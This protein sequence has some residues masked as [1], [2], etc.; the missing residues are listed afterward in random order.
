MLMLSAC[1]STPHSDR[2]RS[3]S[4][5]PSVASHTT[6]PSPAVLSFPQSDYFQHAQVEPLAFLNRLT[7]GSNRSSAAQLAMLG[8][9][10]F[11][12]QQLNAKQSDVPSTIQAQIERMTISQKPFLTMMQELDQQR[13][14]AAKMKGTDDTLRKAYQ[15]ELSRLAREAASR[16]VLRAVYS[17][18][19]LLEQMDWFWM[20]H[21]N[22]SSRKENLRAMLGDFEETAIRPNAL[23]HFRDLLRATILHPA[24]LRYLDNE[25]NAVGKI[26]ENYARELLE[27]HTMGVGSGYTQIDVQELA[28]VLTGLGVNI[29]ADK[30]VQRPAARLRQARE[31]SVR[32]GMTEF[33]PRRHD[34]GDKNLLGVNIPGSGLQEIEQ[35]L[36]LL[37]RH[38]ATARFISQKLAQY[39]VAD[40]PS[41]TL[42]Q[43]MARAFLQTQG[44]IR[45]V[46][47]T[48]FE[49]PE[50][51]ASL[52][53][54]W[55]DPMHYVL[56]SVRLAYEDQLIVNPGPVL[57]WMN[58]LGQQ[59][60]GHQTP[61]GYSM[62]EIAWAS[63]AQMTQRFEV[64]K[65][66]ARGAPALFKTDEEETSAD[67]REL[68][69]FNLSRDAFAKKMVESWSPAAREALNQAANP[70]EWQ[71]FFFSSP[72]MMRR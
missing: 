46:L 31:E 12:M 41:E 43:Q 52:G 58:T 47:K 15:Q 66:I 14:A 24:M 63:P 54:K 22:I 57:S 7:W 8:P 38:P 11:L 19:Q 50:F 21:F 20:N 51:I 9:D 40:E 70:Q 67:H 2:D 44:D 6:I 56:S 30:I 35:V 28:R 1:S 36:D 18:N 33:N 13:E 16:S 68:A 3:Q 37:C 69:H 32:F 34:F 60:N 29:R 53:K 23:G 55:K 39:F 27:L 48:M 64:A 45:H 25:H 65:L 26:N 62:K 4:N 72:E 5:R 49:T 10:R 59:A 61:D 17:S 42:V 71:A